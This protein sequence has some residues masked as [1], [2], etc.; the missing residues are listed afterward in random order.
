MS[1]CADTAYAYP[2]PNS[3]DPEC[4]TLLRRYATLLNEPFQTLN[5]RMLKAEARL[6]W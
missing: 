3:G 4:E 1:Q 6:C 2:I 5:M